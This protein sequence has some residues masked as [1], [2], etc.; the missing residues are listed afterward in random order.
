MSA[1]G[2]DGEREMACAHMASV[3]CRVVLRVQLTL[4]ELEERAWKGPREEA[5]RTREDEMDDFF[6]DLIL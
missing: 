4:R 1:G 5:T 6:R 2:R 3:V